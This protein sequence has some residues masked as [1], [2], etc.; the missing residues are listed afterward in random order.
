MKIARNFSSEQFCNK[1]Q[2]NCK[3]TARKLQENCKKT[4]RELQEKCKKLYNKTT[5]KVKIKL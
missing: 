1:L 5:I 3:K 4:A 2:E